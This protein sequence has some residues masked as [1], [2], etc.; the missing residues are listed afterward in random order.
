[1]APILLDPQKYID[2]HLLL[3]FSFYLS[4]HIFATDELA[5]LFTGSPAPPTAHAQL[6]QQTHES[7]PESA[8]VEVAEENDDEDESL[9]LASLPSIPPPGLDS[10]PLS[11]DPSPDSS[12]HVI[13]SSL[14]GPGVLGLVNP[15]FTIVQLGVDRRLLVNRKRQL[16]MY[17]VWM[18]GK[19]QRT[20]A[21][22]AD[23]NTS[24]S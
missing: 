18:Q 19:F 20:E 13:H 3:L 17:R 16:K 12:V 11:A 4:S 7:V 15:L 9:P 6:Q 21:D 2:F 22:G 8:E 10:D 24:T 23:L 14:Q 1:L 5:L